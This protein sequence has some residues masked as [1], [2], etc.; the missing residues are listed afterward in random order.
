MIQGKTFIITASRIFGDRHGNDIKAMAEAIAH[1][2]T[3]LYVNPPLVGATAA[4]DGSVSGK[5][6]KQAPANPLPNLWVTEAPGAGF[7]VDTASSED[8]FVVLAGQYAET[9]KQTVE[10]LGAEWPDV[11]LIVDNKVPVLPYLSDL[12]PVRMSLFYCNEKSLDSE[13]SKNTDR[14][15]RDAAHSADA[16]IASEPEITSDLRQYNPNT[17]NIGRGVELGGYQ[18]GKDYPRP[19][20]IA[21]IDTK[22]VGCAGTVSSLYLSPETILRMAISLPEITIVLLGKQDPRIDGHPVH[23][24]PNVRFLGAKSDE[25]LPAYISAFDVCIDPAVNNHP[26]SRYRNAIVYYLALGK[27]VISS[28]MEHA[29]PFR[30]H[31]LIARSENDFVEKT[32]KALDV[33]I[34]WSIR[35][36]RAEFART[37][38]WGKCV[39]RLYVVIDVV[40]SERIMKRQAGDDKTLFN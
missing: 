15:R 31:V 32:E 17:Y 14:L 13:A 28:D 36:N 4:K 9:I 1:N 39:E 3:V 2:N 25:E 6:D 29:K 35:Y 26:N 22:I 5:S 23:G 37:F 38:S 12:L 16:V 8:V 7:H 34:P 33:R 21:D 18:F 24:R 11:Y 10:Q 30:D 27:C 40:E 20:D 19:A